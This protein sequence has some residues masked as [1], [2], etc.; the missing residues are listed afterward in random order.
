[1]STFKPVFTQ[2]GGRCRHEL[3]DALDVA[4]DNTSLI[5]AI[6]ADTGLLL[7]LETLESSDLQKLH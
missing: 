1:V 4:S 6:S 5:T 2:N 7:T 3:S